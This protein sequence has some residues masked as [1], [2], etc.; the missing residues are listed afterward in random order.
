MAYTVRQKIKGRI[1]LYEVSSYWDKEK[2]QP[3]QKRKYLGPEK[4]I[5]KKKNDNV[6]VTSENDI[7]IKPSSFVSKSY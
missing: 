4:R 7:A 5:Y 1:Y 6:Q 2:K 3:R